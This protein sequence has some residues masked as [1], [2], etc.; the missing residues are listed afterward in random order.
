MLRAVPYSPQVGS[1]KSSLISALLGDM[2]KLAGRVA[3][4][5]N[6]AYVPQQAWIL[7]ATLRDNILFAQPY[8]PR[9]YAQVVC[10][11]LCGFCRL[12][13]CAESL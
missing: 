1:G 10:C 7:N 2:E 8:D 11:V 4:P 13:S 6:V 12:C 3:L 5:L 9:R